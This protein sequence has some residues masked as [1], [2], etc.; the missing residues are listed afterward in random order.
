[1]LGYSLDELRQLGIRRLTYPPD[2]AAGQKL[3]KELLSGQRD[4]Y[5]REKRYVRRDGSVVWA[6]STALA[7]RDADGRL[8]YIISMVEDFTE[9]KELA[10]EILTAREKEQQRLG[11]DLHDGCAGTSLG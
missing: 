4:H 1:M 6:Q 2:I 9:R 5:Q 3:H 8:R 11:Q 10:D 7:V